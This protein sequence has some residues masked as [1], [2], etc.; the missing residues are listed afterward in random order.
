MSMKFT[1]Y[2]KDEYGLHPLY[3]IRRT[4]TDFYTNDL[5]TN[6]RNHFSYHESGTSA[7][8]DPI[9]RKYPEM[10]V[11]KDRPPLAEFCGAESILTLNIGMN[12][13]PAQKTRLPKSGDMVFEIEVPFSLEII[14]SNKDIDLPLLSDRITVDVQKWLDVKPVVIVEAYKL[15]NST[16][17]LFRF[18]QKHP[19]KFG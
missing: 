10:R 19:I 12:N 4:K 7:H 11:Q 16:L 18:D 5:Q 1:I 2:Y 13:L 9:S 15:I 17:C 3:E 8:K 6:N 14:I